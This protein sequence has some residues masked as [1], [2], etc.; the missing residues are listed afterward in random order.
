MNSNCKRG[1]YSPA[2]VKNSIPDP[3]EGES[4]INN[5]RPMNKDQPANRSSTPKPV[6]QSDVADAKMQRADEYADTKIKEIEAKISTFDTA[7]SKI[8]SNV[9]VKIPDEVKKMTQDFKKN[10]NE[11]GKK[12]DKVDEIKGTINRWLLKVLAF[13][14]AIVCLSFLITLWTSVKYA[15]AKQRFEEADKEWHNANTAVCK[16]DSMRNA[17]DYRHDFGEWMIKRYGKYGN[18]FSVFKQEYKYR[19]K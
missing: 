19:N 1:Q 7:V 18:D 6:K 3:K 8:P 15:D 5:G 11:L 9:P 14:F 13:N 17:R 12:L 16:M 4:S 10:L 2:Q